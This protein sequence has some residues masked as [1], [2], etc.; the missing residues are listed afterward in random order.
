MTSKTQF[1][2]CSISKQ[3]VYQFHHDVY[4]LSTYAATLCELV[5]L[6]LL[7]TRVSGLKTPYTRNIGR[8]PNG[9]CDPK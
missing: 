1:L 6:V 7:L 9:I 5:Y 8:D 4:Y 3:I 2:I